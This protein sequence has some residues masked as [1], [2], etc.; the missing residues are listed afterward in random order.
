MQTAQYNRSKVSP[1]K[2]DPRKKCAFIFQIFWK[3][4]L[5]IYTLSTAWDD[6]NKQNC[7][8]TAL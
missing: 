8:S 7:T 4:I 3:N 1:D 6:K 2:V 5:N